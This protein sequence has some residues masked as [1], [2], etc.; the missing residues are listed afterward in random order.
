V[1]PALERLDDILVR[2]ERVVVAAMLSVMGFVVFLDVMHR[3]STRDGSPLANPVVVAPVGIVV[4]ILALRTRGVSGAVPK[5]VAI[6]V[7]IAAAQAAFVRL[8][9]SGLVWSQTLALALTLW[10]GTIGASLAAHQRR[11]LAL[12]IGSKL[13]PPAIAPKVV[14]LGHVLTALFCVGL[15]GLACRSILGYDIDGQH[16]PGHYDVWSDSQGSAG[17]LTGTPIPKWAAMLSIPYGMAALT[18][19]FLLEAVRTWNGQVEIGGDD[20]LHQLGIDAE[21][22]S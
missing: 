7:G 8:V 15:F 10:L 17:T 4:S 19:R 6:G 14:A 12:D 11:H 1:I 16:I 5:G 22:A 3:V 20:T 2:I 9:P 21:E 13:W 18:F